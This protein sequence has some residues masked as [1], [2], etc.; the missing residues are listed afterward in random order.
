MWHQWTNSQNKIASINATVVTP[1]GTGGD[2]FFGTSG[3]R[4]ALQNVA[5]VPSLAP[6]Q[7][8]VA[9]GR[10]TYRG[11][12][13]EDP[14]APGGTTLVAELLPEAVVIGGAPGAPVTGVALANLTIAHTAAGLEEQ[15]LASG[16]GGQSNSD[17]TSAAVHVRYALA[18]SLTGLE[19]TGTGGYAAWLDVG[20]TSCALT[21]CLLTDL[22]QGGVRVGNGD[23]TGAP[24][25]APAHSN[26]IA[27]CVISDGG[28]VVPAGTGVLAQECS[29][30]TITHNH[31]HHLRYTG[32]TTGW[33]WGYM[34][35]S[36]AGQTVSFNHIHDIFLGEL[37][38]GGCIYNLGRSPGTRIDHNLCHDT[39]AY[40]YGGWGIYTDEVR[41]SVRRAA[42]QWWLVVAAAAAAAVASL[43]GGD[44][45]QEGVGCATPPAAAQLVCAPCSL[46]GLE[47]LSGRLRTTYI[48]PSGESGG[49][50]LCLLSGGA[51]PS[52]PSRRQS[53]ALAA[54][55][56]PSLCVFVS[57]GE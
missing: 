30:T 21:Q 42:L 24:A 20:S 9:G 32:V 39:D 38:D 11:L 3:N 41:C 35:T 31:I 48:Q 50:A 4:W 18:A 47:Q 12:P 29:N 53:A 1:V 13:G 10:I 6:G 55:L 7:F 34:A 2:P 15:C 17:A 56:P 19:L 51:T 26:S 22:G 37:T 46:P 49:A 27:D 25:T 52:P 14:T 57:W 16:C 40:N 54:A 33:T 23:D 8:F 43:G 36:D 5:D 44:V 28:H 45:E